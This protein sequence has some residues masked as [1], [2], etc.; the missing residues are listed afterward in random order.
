[1]VERATSSFPRVRRL[2]SKMSKSF[3]ETVSNC[4]FASSVKLHRFSMF[5]ET[6]DLPRKMVPI[7]V[8]S[9]LLDWMLEYSFT[10]AVSSSYII[11]PLR[12]L[13]RF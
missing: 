9:H 3:W 12:S 10:H 13:L 2:N 8:E 7:G 5:F 1:M 6:N 4:C 11:A